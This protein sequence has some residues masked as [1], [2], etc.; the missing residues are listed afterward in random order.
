[1]KPHDIRHFRAGRGHLTTGC[2]ERQDGAVNEWPEPAFLLGEGTDE[3]LSVAWRLDLSVPPQS[4][5]RAWIFISS[6]SGGRHGTMINL[7]WPGRLGTRFYAF[8]DQERQIACVVGSVPL[9]CERVFAV[10]EGGSE[11]DAVLI[12]PPEAPLKFYM[13]LVNRRPQRLFSTHSVG[14]ERGGEWVEDPIPDLFSA[15]G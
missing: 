4:G 9:D 11:K 12:G 2:V 1:M 5:G 3:E 7:N 6:V 13:L 14:R 15:P 8:V 10:F